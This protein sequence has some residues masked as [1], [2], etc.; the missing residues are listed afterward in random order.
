[1][2]VGASTAPISATTMGAD[3]TGICPAWTCRDTMNRAPIAARLTSRSPEAA[4]TDPRS[5]LRTPA[6]STRCQDVSSW[7]RR[8]GIAPASAISDSPC[9]VSMMSEV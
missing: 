3:E 8:R 7:D 2:A 5:A 9:T 6:R 1:M 4:S